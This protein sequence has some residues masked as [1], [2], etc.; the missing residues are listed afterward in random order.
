MTEQ[1]K[2]EVVRNAIHS[3]LYSKVA[4]ILAT[5]SSSRIEAALVV[6]FTD[7]DCIT[8]ESIKRDI[9]KAVTEAQQHREKQQLSDLPKLKDLEQTINK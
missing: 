6:A 8:E 5:N 4:Q 3:G 1:R 2:K 7:I 9:D